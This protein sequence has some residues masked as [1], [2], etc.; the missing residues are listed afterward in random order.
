MAELK[1]KKN[2]A[3]V[4]AFLEQVTDPV[5]QEDALWVSQVMGEVVGEPAV[6]YGS[7][8][9]GF[10]SYDFT[11]A[12]GKAGSW[13]LVGFSPRKQN[14]VLYIMPGFSKY[15]ELLAQLGKHKIGKSCLYVKKLA[16]IDRTILKQLIAESVAFMRQKYAT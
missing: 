2:Q 7:S 14:L 6:M 10:G 16:D 1:T 15:E 9:V 8:I 3:S 4:Q 13:F 11:Y 5:K 12:S